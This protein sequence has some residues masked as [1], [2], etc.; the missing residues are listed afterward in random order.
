M[1]QT[2]IR[3]APLLHFHPLFVKELTRRFYVWSG[4]DYKMD[5]ALLN[6]QGGTEPTNYNSTCHMDQQSFILHVSNGM[7]YY[8]HKPIPQV[9]EA[10]L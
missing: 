6:F 9:E 3:V 4:K 1:K 7:M 10:T 8:T 5:L 2:H